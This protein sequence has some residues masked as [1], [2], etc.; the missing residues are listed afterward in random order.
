M[1]SSSVWPDWS[2]GDMND[3]DMSWVVFVLILAVCCM[4]SRVYDQTSRLVIYM[5]RVCREVER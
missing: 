3:A 5:L 1:G 2:A 4:M